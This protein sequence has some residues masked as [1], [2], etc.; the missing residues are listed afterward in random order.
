MS[1]RDSSAQQADILVSF[2]AHRN[3]VALTTLKKRSAVSSPKAKVIGS[4]P[5]GCTSKIIHLG[6]RYPSVHTFGLAF[7]IPP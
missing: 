7:V 3:V 5:I 6:L 1:V 2:S 4:T